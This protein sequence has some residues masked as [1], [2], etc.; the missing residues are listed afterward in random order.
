M[1][2]YFITGE[3]LSAD[4]LGQLIDEAEMLKEKRFSSADSS[5]SGKSV[6]LIFE[7][8]STRT[9]ISFE[10]GVLELDGNPIVLKGDDLQLARGESIK[11]TALVLSRYV[12]GIVLRTGGHNKIEELAKYSAAPVINALTEDH[13]PCQA[14]ADL[15]TIKER[16]GSLSGLKLAYVGDGNNVAT[17]L[18]L[19]APRLGVQVVIATPPKFAPDQEIVERAIAQADGLVELTDDPEKAVAGADAVYTDVWISMGDE[20]EADWR[21]KILAPYQVNR[22]LLGLASKRAIVLHCLP[23]HPGEEITED[24]LYS[25]RSAVWDQAENRL[26]TQKALLKLLIV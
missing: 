21:R 16:V 3:E 5:L 26:H 15:L 20:Q 25:D 8:P 14:L 24:V 1:A 19:I 6:A 23:A 11:D 22:K 7:K 12:Q 4:E 2:N 10:V 18:L 17:S 9:R 13:H